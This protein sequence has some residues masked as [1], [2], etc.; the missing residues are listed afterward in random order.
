M[1][2]HTTALGALVL[3][4]PATQCVPET[5]YPAFMRAD[6]TVFNDGVGVFTLLAS[7]CGVR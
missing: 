3:K 1:T 4:A 2:S 5:L 7:S 6:H